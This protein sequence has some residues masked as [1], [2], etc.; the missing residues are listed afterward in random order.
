[1]GGKKVVCVNCRSNKVVLAGSYE[2]KAHGER[3]RLRCRNCG[4]FFIMRDKTFRR[5]HPYYIFKRIKAYAKRRKT[6]I[7]K[8]DSRKKTTY[9]GREIAGLLNVSQSFVY[10]VLKKHL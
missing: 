5:K 7:N 2:T 1:M 9:S 4:R 3:K 6:Y 8:F 10:G